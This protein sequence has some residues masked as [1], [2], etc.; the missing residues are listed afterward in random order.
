MTI[1]AFVFGTLSG[2]DCAFS[3]PQGVNQFP[4]HRQLEIYQLMFECQ[5][6]GFKFQGFFKLPDFSGKI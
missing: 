1:H 6:D 5:V 3:W 4:C 2:V